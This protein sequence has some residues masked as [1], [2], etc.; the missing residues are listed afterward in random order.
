[1]FVTSHAL[2][3]SETSDASQLE[4]LYTNSTARYNF[5]ITSSV[6]IPLLWVISHVLS[7]QLAALPQGP[8]FTFQNTEGLTIQKNKKIKKESFQMERKTESTKVKQY[9]QAGALLCQA[10]VK[11]EV[12][13]EIGVEVEACH[14]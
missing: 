8:G 11:L 2:L 9:I 4:Y 6:L 5:L 14:Y 1:M 13:V 3:V 7:Q 12:V 10:Q